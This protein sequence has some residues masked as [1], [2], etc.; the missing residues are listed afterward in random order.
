LAR[1][2]EIRKRIQ[3]IKKTQKITRAMKLVSAAKFARAQGA[4]QAA[5]PYAQKLAEV[6]ASVANGVDA[7]A[8]PLLTVRNPVR[9]VDVVVFTSDRGLCGAY[10][11][12]IVKFAERMIAKRRPEVESISIISVGRKGGDLLKSRRTAPI[13]HRWSGLARVEPGMATEIA[14]FLVE[15][16]QSGAADEVVLVYSE[17]VSALTQRPGSHLLLPLKPP[18]AAGGPVYTV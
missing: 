4:I 10:N 7:D 11:S 1:Y 15:R 17:F 13:A 2:R 6:L 5:R 8:H 9:K 12:N 14:Q 3:G 18:A 16:Y